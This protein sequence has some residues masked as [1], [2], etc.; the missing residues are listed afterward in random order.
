MRHTAIG[1]LVFC[2]IAGIAF[3]HSGVTNPAVKARME[4]M[5]KVQDATAVLGKMAQKAIPFD[6]AEAEAARLQ[7]IETATAIPSAFEAPE[8]DPKSEA[9]LAIWRDWDDFQSSAQNMQTVAQTLDTSSLNTLRTGMG[10]LGKSCKSCHAAF[11][12]EK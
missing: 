9:R 1:T 2:L 10:Q 3:A 8:T 12:I 5:S 6:T 4:L 11:R 7:L